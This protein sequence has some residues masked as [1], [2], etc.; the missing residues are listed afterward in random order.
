METAQIQ[1]AAELELYF[2]SDA[3]QFMFLILFNWHNRT[4]MW[5]LLPSVFQRQGDTA[6]IK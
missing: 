3:N 4:A 2:V 1:Q 5:T 6:E